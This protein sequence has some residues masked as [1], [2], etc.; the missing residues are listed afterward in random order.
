VASDFTFNESKR[1]GNYEAAGF[2]ISNASG[3]INAMGWGGEENSDFDWLLMPSEIGET[4][5]LPVGDYLYVTANLD[6]YRIVLL[7][8]RWAYGGFAGGFCW[9]C[10]DGVGARYRTVG[11]RLVYVP[12][13]KKQHI[14]TTDL[15]VTLPTLPTIAGTNT[16]SVETQVQPSSVKIKGKIKGVS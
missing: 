12:Q 14:Y 15:D 10:T 11:G 4:S 3:Y 5:A 8:G 16:L 9:A 6:G 1:D 7:G 13:I 2:T